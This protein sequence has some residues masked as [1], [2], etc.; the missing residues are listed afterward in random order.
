MTPMLQRLLADPRAKRMLRW[1]G[2]V[3]LGVVSFV[4]ALQATFPYQRVADKAIE[5]LSPRYD[6][7]IGEVARGWLP[8]KMILR[9]VTLRSRPAKPDDAVSTMFFER[10]EIDVNLI[11]S[12]L[13]RR[14]DTDLELAVG[15]G[16]LAGSIAI[17]KDDVDVDLEGKDMPADGVPGLA[18][19]I[20]LPMTGKIDPLFQLE[21][22]GNDWRQATGRIR[23]VCPAGCT[24]GDGVS[25]LKFKLKPGSRQAA[26]ASEGV[27]I[28]KMFIDRFALQVDIGKGKL[29]I[30]TW[31]LKSK[32]LEATIELQVQLAKAIAESTI[33]SGC[34]KYKPS[35]EL[36]E[37]APKTQAAL[38]S[39]GAPLAPDGNYNILLSGRLGE[40]KRLPRVCGAGAD[41]ADSATATGRTRRPSLDRGGPDEQ[42]M[43]IQVPNNPL[44]PPD[45]VQPL[46][47]PPPPEPAPGA[48]GAGAGSGAPP[49]EVAPALSGGAAPQPGAPGAPA[50]PPPTPPGTPAETA[51]PGGP[52]PVPAPS[53]DP[54][55]PPPPPPQPGEVPAGEPSPTGEGEIR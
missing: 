53:V 1:A 40:M 10:V 26:F 13:G 33:T 43:T 14:L 45:D 16:Y 5:V 6:V 31:E 4:L 2:W 22:P 24:V 20:G 34:L 25:K 23:L 8:G 27:T 21:L 15:G 12:A 42:G 46:P 37:R 38:M 54:A 19:S 11:A 52:E 17:G 3:A 7:T 35:A 41:A 49:P 48:I 36:S 44:P 50:A 47:P 9:G 28:D 18:D 29:G 51:P 39:T 55:A 30:T 32:D